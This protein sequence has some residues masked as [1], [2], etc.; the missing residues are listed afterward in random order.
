ML[1][2]SNQKGWSSKQTTPKKRASHENSSG[3]LTF[4][5]LKQA[6]I[7]DEASQP[8]QDSALDH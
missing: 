1:S 3:I 2:W 4:G 5:A 8:Q 6:L 7:D